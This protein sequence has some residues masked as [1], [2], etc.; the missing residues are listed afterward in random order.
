[1]TEKEDS[2]FYEHLDLSSVGK[3]VLWTFYDDRS[4]K[5]CLFLER[6]RNILMFPQDILV[7]PTLREP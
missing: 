7:M 2:V 6:A 5:F 3:E 4:L 1:M